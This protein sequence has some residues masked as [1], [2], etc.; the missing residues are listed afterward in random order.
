MKKRVKFAVLSGLVSYGAPILKL[1]KKTIRWEE[2]PKINT[3]KKIYALWHGHAL[4][5]ALFGINKG[6]YVLVSR[7]RDG[8]L[9]GRVLKT[10]GYKIIRG[11]SE[12]GR[13]GKGAREG[14]IKLL[15]VLKKGNS[16]AIT[17]DG[18]KGPAF[19]AKRGVVFLAKKTGAPIVPITVHFDRAIR[20]NSWDKFIIPLPFS[21]AF[22]RLGDEIVVKPDDDIDKKTKEVESALLRIS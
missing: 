2:K 3:H 21:R 13:K 17:V 19:K 8:E 4:G 9:T 16:V 14:T 20:L 10:L 18:P 11:S 6:V 15:E 22:V 5:V 12:E 1:L 7:F